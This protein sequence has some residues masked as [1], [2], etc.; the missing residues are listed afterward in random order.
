MRMLTGLVL[1]A[2][3]AAGSGCA[4]PDWIDQTL[5]TVDVTGVWRGAFAR[6]GAGGGKSNVELALQQ[7]GPKVNGQLKGI[8]TAEYGLVEG[9]V[10][11]DVFSFRTRRGDVTGELQVSGDEMV[12]PVTT[13]TGPGSVTLQRQP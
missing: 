13:T 11:G 4:R 9:T 6:A 12:G 3:L 10:N 7:S 2:L 1:T 5:V 8:S